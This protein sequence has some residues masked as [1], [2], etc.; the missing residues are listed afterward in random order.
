MVCVLEEILSRIQSKFGDTLQT[1]PQV[2]LYLRNSKRSYRSR[3]H[4]YLSKPILVGR[5]QPSLDEI[6]LR[7]ATSRPN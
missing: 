3:L 4:E 1:F 7:N 6:H 2:S 5:Y